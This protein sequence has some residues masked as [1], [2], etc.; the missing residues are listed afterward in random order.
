M[1]G[2]QSLASAALLVTH[3][4]LPSEDAGLSGLGYT[5]SE[6]SPEQHAGVPLPSQSNEG[7]QLYSRAFCG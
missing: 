2:L 6:G 3:P 4:L 5:L 1:Q 7:A